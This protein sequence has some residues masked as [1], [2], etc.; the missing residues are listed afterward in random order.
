VLAVFVH[1]TGGDPDRSPSLCWLEHLGDCN[2][3]SCLWTTPLTQ[4][5][6]YIYI[7][8]PSTTCVTRLSKS[9]EILLVPQDDIPLG[10]LVLFPLPGNGQGVTNTTTTTFQCT[11]VR[12]GAPSAFTSHNLLWRVTLIPSSTPP[13]TTTS[14]I[15]Y[16]TATK[17][18]AYQE[19]Q[20]L[21]LC[22]EIVRLPGHLLFNDEDDGYRL[23]WVVDSRWDMAEV[24]CGLSTSEESSVVSFL[25]GNGA[26][27]SH[28]PILTRQ[29]SWEKVGSSKLEC[30]MSHNAKR[31]GDGN[32]GSNCG[33][34]RTTTP[35]STTTS[36]ANDVVE[37]D[38][39]GLTIACEAFLNVETL[40]MEILSHFKSMKDERHPEYYYNLISVTHGGRVAELVVAFLTH[41]TSTAPSSTPIMMMTTTASTPPKTQHQQRQRRQLAFFVQVDLFHRGSFRVLEW[42]QH[43]KPAPSSTTTTAAA[44]NGMARGREGAAVAAAAESVQLRKWCN[45]LALNRRLRSVGAGPYSIHPTTSTTIGKET[46]HLHSINWGHRIVSGWGGAGS[47][48]TRGGGPSVAGLASSSSPDNFLDHDESDDYDPN[49]WQS[50]YESVVQQNHASA[51]SSEAATVTTTTTMTKTEPVPPKQISFSSLYPDCD[52]VTNQAVMSYQP[53]PLLVSKAAPVQLFYG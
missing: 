22:N 24:G 39:S 33:G 53:V 26:K 10:T 30:K 25:Q 50:Y 11:N 34:K 12:I 6:I 2:K 40:L 17:L 8:C 37:V 28:E 9:M 51:L 36:A 31:Q 7:L 15:N 20:P 21:L 43:P 49:I 42:V 45:V 48:S 4:S 16:S 27:S 5:Y 52:L 29:S 44:R 46:A 19:R 3:H 14:S 18:L 47:T 38:D 13:T 23:T 35:T 1:G 32:Q 41:P